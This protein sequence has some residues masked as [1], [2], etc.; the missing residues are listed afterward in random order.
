MEQKKQSNNIIHIVGGSILIA[1]LFFGG[2]S[3]FFSGPKVENKVTAAAVSSVADAPSAE[4]AKIV[5]GVQEVTLGWGKFNYAPEVI[6]VKKEMTV[7]ITADLQRLSGCFRSLQIPELGVSKQFT[8]SD[9]VLEFTP[10]KTGTF[11][12]N[13][14]MGMGS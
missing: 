2:I 5:N 4:T 6:T 3:L 9:T 12:F 7:R 11:T 13:C 1:I 14:A 8:E 10:K